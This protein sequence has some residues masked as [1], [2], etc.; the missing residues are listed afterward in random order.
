MLEIFRRIWIG[1]NVLLRGIVTAQSRFLMAVTWIVG[2]APVALAFKVLGR[3]LIDR[4]PADPN[5]A[6]YRA[7]RSGKPMEMD[8]AARMF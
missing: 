3:R 2:V 7:E 8:E 1:W 6:T 5:A 4:A